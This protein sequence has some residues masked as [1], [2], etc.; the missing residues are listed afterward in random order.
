[1]CMLA[2]EAW[3]CINNVECLKL[4]D[5]DGEN[6]ASLLKVGNDSSGVHKNPLTHI[7]ISIP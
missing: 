3:I 2:A 5:R 4:Y 6:E 7:Y 1:M